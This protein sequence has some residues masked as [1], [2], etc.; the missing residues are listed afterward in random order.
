MK[1]TNASYFIA[2]VPGEPVLTE[3]REFKY[4]FLEKYGSKAA[5]KSPAHITLFPP[6]QIR[7][8]EETK[9]FALLDRFATAY[10]SFHLQLQGFD[11]FAP[12]VI[13]V[14]PLPHP[15]LEKMQESLLNYLNKELNLGNKSF[16]QNPFHP[17]IT[18]ASRD[19]NKEDFLKAWE[20]FKGKAYE[21]QI[22]VT[23]VCLLKLKEQSWEIIHESKL[24]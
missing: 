6:F 18:L 16:L 21:R 10:P 7:T 17:H 23:K 5:L 3:I 4:Y 13:F 20:E 2:L 8:T 24:S 9:M 11:T 15:L 12:R 1:N 19:L 14:R 22:E